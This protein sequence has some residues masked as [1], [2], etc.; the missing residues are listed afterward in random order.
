MATP[1]YLDKQKCPCSSLKKQIHHF[2]PSDSY[3]QC[4][5][6]IVMF[7]EALTVLI[8]QSSHFRVTRAF[9][10]IFLVD[11]RACGAVRRYIRQIF[12]SLPPI[13]DMMV[14]LLFFIC[15]YAL[16]GY[17]LFSHHQNNLYFK[18]LSDSFVSMFV[19]LTT[20]KYVPRL[21]IS[22]IEKRPLQLSGRDDAFLRHIEVVRRLLHLV[23][24]DRALR[25]DELGET[26]L[27]FHKPGFHPPCLFQML[28]VV[29]ETFTGIEK[30]KFRKLLLHKR[31]ACQLAFR[32]LVSKQNPN[33]VRFK[34]FQG[35]MRYYAPRICKPLKK[36]LPPLQP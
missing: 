5:T 31:K 18:T 28:A 2:R 6:L 21:K 35:L 9:R 14:L 25:F 16:L 10:P 19:L 11:T 1:S 17:F 36:L 13:L 29:Y 33:A 30:D 7:V 26:R 20:A 15:S 27:P 22:V 23:H 12:Q 8:R 3:F 34:Q 24:I 32:L 4:A